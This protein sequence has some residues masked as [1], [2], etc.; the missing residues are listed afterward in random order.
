MFVEPIVE[1][2]CLDL[3]QKV[4]F[5]QE[6]IFVKHGKL[7]YLILTLGLGSFIKTIR[8]LLMFLDDQLWY[9][10]SY[11]WINSQYWQ[12]FW[13]VIIC[14]GMNVFGLYRTFNIF[15]YVFWGRYEFYLKLFLVVWNLAI[16]LRTL[17]I[18]EYWFGF[19]RMLMNIYASSEMDLIFM[20]KLRF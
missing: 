2:R 12:G 20:S 5:S 7:L 19:I 11:W 9:S 17:C 16:Y 4:P 13:Y 15:V 1:L 6:E 10:L 18:C 8:C 3:N 14:R